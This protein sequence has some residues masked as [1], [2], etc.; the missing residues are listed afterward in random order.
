MFVQTYKNTI[1]MLFRTP[2]FWM[3]LAFLIAALIYG[4]LVVIKSA[5]A[6]ERLYDLDSYHNLI[7][8]IPIARI[9]IYPMPLF[10]AVTT[11]LILNRDYGDKFFEIEK[12]YNM[13]PMRYLL[14]R[15]SALITVNG[16]LVIGLSFAFIHL[17]VLPRGGVE[18]MTTEE[19]LFDS[20]VR[21]MRVN[22]LL[23]IPSLLTFITVTYTVGTLFQS[24]YAAM[25]ASSVYVIFFY[26]TQL[27][28]HMKWQPIYQVYFRYL[29]LTPRALRLY[30]AMADTSYFERTMSK[31]NDNFVHVILGFCSL[32]AFTALGM[33]ISAFR[34]RRRAE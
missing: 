6:S 12:A 27:T 10:A 11:V 4:N 25:I 22:L 32:A 23:C 14:G 1:K 5:F 17:A 16:M 3:M 34:I 30:A 29:N 7:N 26:L 2:S 15:L 20:F 24:G 8:N 28:L 33:F 13:T 19:Y 18:G 21:I 31:Y 9:M